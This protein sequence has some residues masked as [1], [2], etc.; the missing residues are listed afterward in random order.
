M[1]NGWISEALL[2]ARR[3]SGTGD[4]RETGVL[5]EGGAQTRLVGIVGDPMG[6]VRE[7]EGG[8]G[9]FERLDSLFGSVAVV[10]AVVP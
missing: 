8:E 9:E 10:V 7:P 2:A 3:A 6:G 1:V 5:G 4:R